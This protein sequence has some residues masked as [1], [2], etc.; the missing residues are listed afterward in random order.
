MLL[1]QTGGPEM[2]P[3]PSRALR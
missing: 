1:S 2:E 3:S